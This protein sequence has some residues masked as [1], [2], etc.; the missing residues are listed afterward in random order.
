MEKLQYELKRID[1]SRIEPN[2]NNPRGKNIRENDDQFDYLKRSI[3]QF[4]LIVP[5]IVQQ[6]RGKTEKYRLLDG[7]RRFLALRELGIKE[8]PA[9]VIT[10][11]I[12]DERARNVMFH[13]HTNRVQWGAF[14][15]CR[16]LEPIYESVKSD[17][18]NDE[19]RIAK[20][21]VRLTGTNTRTINDRLKFLRWPDEIKRYVYNKENGLYWTV[22]EIESGIIAP[23]QKN[24]PAYFERVSADEVRKLLFKKYLKGVVRAGTE[25][26]KVRPIIRTPEADKDRHRY[27]YKLFKKLVETLHYTF[28]EAGEDFSSRYPDAAEAVALSYSKMR[29]RILKTASMLNE[30]GVLASRTMKDKQIDNLRQALDELQSAIDNFREQA[31][32]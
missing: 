31:E 21:L 17:F 19:N 16:A 15:Q 25:V 7:E 5:L 18:E 22:V 12:D 9:N 3:T 14:Q 28:D 20:E 32:L 24:F 8:A 23:A 13:I 29:S 11:E 26:R 4:G 10:A 30:S 6:M 1:I 2:P 27:A